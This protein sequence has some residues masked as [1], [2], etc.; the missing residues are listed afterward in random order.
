MRH[1]MSH[2]KIEEVPGNPNKKYL[3]YSDGSARVATET[4]IMLWVLVHL[5][6]RCDAASV[7]DSI[8]AIASRIAK[9]EAALQSEKINVNTATSIELTRLKGIGKVTAKAIIKDRS[10]NPFKSI[11]DF[12]ERYR[13][14][15]MSVAAQMI[16]V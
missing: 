15:D 8:S 16:E 2:F 1:L 11:E 7:M 14:D 12:L 5:V 6:D 10:E 4:E 13:V 9:E 3:R